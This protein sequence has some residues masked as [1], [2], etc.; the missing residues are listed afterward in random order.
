[1]V[2]ISW[3][4]APG[5]NWLNNPAEKIIPMMTIRQSQPQLKIEQDFRSLVYRAL[6]D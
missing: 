3:E 2:S 6:D 5:T 4:S 1:M